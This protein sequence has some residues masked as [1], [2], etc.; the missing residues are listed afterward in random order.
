MVTKANKTIL[1]KTFV[2]GANHGQYLQAYGLLLAIKSISKKYKIYHP[3]YNNHWFQELLSQTR[4]LTLIKY[5][6]FLYYWTKRFRFKSK[7]CRNG[8][9]FG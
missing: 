3:F 4:D 9:K 6:V 5:L 2:L 8:Q 7:N 1:I